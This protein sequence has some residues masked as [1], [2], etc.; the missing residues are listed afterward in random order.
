MVAL[1]TGYQARLGEL[2]LQYVRYVLLD[3]LSSVCMDA[4]TAGM[5][6][7]PVKELALCQQCL[8]AKC[9]ICETNSSDTPLIWNDFKKHII[10][11]T[12]KPKGEEQNSIR[13][14]PVIVI[15]LQGL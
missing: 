6:L 1:Y 9:D 2:I 3:K 13:R 12:I 8:Y 7:Y 10:H 14:W 4:C 5:W 11:P 15:T